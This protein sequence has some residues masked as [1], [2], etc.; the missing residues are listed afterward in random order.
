MEQEPD[1]TAANAA[2][3]EDGIKPSSLIYGV[4]CNGNSS[5]TAIITDDDLAKID[6]YLDDGMLEWFKCMTPEKE[7]QLYKIQSSKILFAMFG[8]L[9]KATHVEI[10]IK[11]L[12]LGVIF[13]LMESINEF[14]NG[15]AISIMD[16]D[17][18][19]VRIR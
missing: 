19:L 1:M 13:S 6:L 15:V 7:M 2:T 3:N 16:Y 5:A 17:N 12:S 10:C 4:D 18:S 14:F 9:M 8:K 11:S